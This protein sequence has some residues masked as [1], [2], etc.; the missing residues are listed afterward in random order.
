[1]SLTPE[2]LMTAVEQVVGELEDFA[3]AII[4]ELLGYKY[5]KINAVQ[6]ENVISFSDY[7]NWSNAYTDTNYD[8][9]IRA[10][11]AD[12]IDIGGQ[13]TEKLTTGFK[14]WVEEACTLWFNCHSP[15]VW[16]QT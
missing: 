3:Q 5:G 11:N 8:V 6:G 13:V 16:I 9:E 4:I 1:M 12:G 15:K 2:Q 14:V 10:Y 7:S